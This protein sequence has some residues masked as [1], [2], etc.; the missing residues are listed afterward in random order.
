M[1][2]ILAT[3]PGEAQ[4]QDAALQKAAQIALGMG[5]DALLLPVVLA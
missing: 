2:A 3:R 1:A 5:R 4:S